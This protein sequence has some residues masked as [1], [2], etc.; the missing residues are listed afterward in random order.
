MKE[1]IEGM[2]C[3]GLGTVG[4]NERSLLDSKQSPVQ[5]VAEALRKFDR[6]FVAKQ[7]HNILHAIVDSSAVPASFKMVLDPD[8][9][10]RREIALEIIGQLPARLIAIDFYGP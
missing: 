9:Q 3:Q 6:P 2:S 4:A 7:L 10:L 1:K 8:S 5:A